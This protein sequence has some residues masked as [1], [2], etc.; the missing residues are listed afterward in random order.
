MN[1]ISAVLPKLMAAVQSDNPLLGATTGP[2]TPSTSSTGSTGSTSGSTSTGAP[3]Q[4]GGLD[5]NTFLQLLVSQ[6]SNQDPMNPTD[7]TTYIT[8]EAEFSMV[9][10]MNSMAAQNT[11]ILNSQQRQ[12]ASSYIGKDVNYTDSTGALVGGTVA[13]ASP[14]SAGAFVRIGGV[15]VP[16]SSISEV[17][18]PSSGVTTIAPTAVTPV[19]TTTD[20]TTTTPRRRTRPPPPRPQPPPRQ[21]PRPQWTRPRPRNPTAAQPPTP[22]SHDLLAQ[23]PERP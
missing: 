18:G 2:A 23:T 3:A 21:P 10:S 17:F 7:S 11:S 14:G 16:L 8:E 13:S 5:S 4:V 12:E 19:A 6:I 9:Q 22:L 20:P 1:P 15:Q